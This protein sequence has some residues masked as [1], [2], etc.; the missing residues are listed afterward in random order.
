MN[1]TSAKG[2]C[3]GP[4]S[5]WNEQVKSQ[6]HWN[7]REREQGKNEGR[8]R[9]LLMHPQSNQY[10][11]R[12]A[13]SSA[14]VTVRLVCKRPRLSTSIWPN[15]MKCGDGF[16]SLYTHLWGSPWWPSWLRNSQATW[17]KTITYAWIVCCSLRS[18]LEREFPLVV[19]RATS[20]RPY[21][22][23]QSIGSSA[24]LAGWR[25]STVKVSDKFR[26]TCG[27]TRGM[28]IAFNE[29]VRAFPLPWKS[30]IWVA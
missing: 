23:P 27:E 15:N 10:P 11:I 7:L 30:T 22:A 20:G 17:M 25:W 28:D 29:N 6:R 1:I 21:K 3:P 12:S 13:Q 5:L 16:I 24:R 2:V 4:M 19:K 18:P 26:C 8:P 9:E 14:S